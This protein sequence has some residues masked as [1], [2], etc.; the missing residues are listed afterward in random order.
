MLHED[1][2]EYLTGYPQVAPLADTAMFDE[3]VAEIS[4]DGPVR[5][6]DVMGSAR[7]VLLRHLLQQTKLGQ[8]AARVVRDR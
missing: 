7:T 5:L 8:R 6:E 4:D 2:T 1:P 3:R